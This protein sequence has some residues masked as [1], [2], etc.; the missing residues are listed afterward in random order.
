MEFS[1][2]LA[3]AL[4]TTLARRRLSKSVAPLSYILALVLVLVLSIC[5]V[6]EEAP[7]DVIDKFNVSSVA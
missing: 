3:D 7:P 2:S 6:C 4:C 5:P 1:S